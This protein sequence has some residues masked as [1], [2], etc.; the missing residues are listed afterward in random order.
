MNQRPQLSSLDLWSDHEQLCKQLLRDALA[1]LEDSPIDADE[2][3]LNRLLY[4]AIIR[5]SQRASESGD[6]V[7]VVVPEGRNPPAASDKER[8]EREFKTPDFYWAYIDPLASD[9]NDASKQ[10]VVECKRL[11]KPIS[12]YAREYVKSGIARFINIG[13]GYGKGVRSGAM[14]GY[15]QEVFLDEALMGV[16]RQ[17][18]EDAIPDL[19][20]LR[21]DGESS[22]ELVHQVT[23]QFTVSPFQLTHVWTRIGPEPV[24]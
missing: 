1:E 12:R 10:F 23:R 18:A 4:R 6:H 5:V 3:D 20:A 8:A 2:N 11:A 16:N 22:A 17:A 13:H 7:P 9:P 21:R 24:P 19:L 15:L 14:V